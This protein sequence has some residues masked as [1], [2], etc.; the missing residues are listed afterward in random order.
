MAQEGYAAANGI[1]LWRT[2]V[3]HVHRVCKRVKPSAVIRCKQC[4]CISTAFIGFASGCLQDGKP[5]DETV[6]SLH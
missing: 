6:T 4:N 3:N 2:D 5:P 1:G